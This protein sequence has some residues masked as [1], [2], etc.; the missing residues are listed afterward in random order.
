MKLA[1]LIGVSEY[2]FQNSL[3]ACANDLKLINN[4]LEKLN[5]FE[6]I[7]VIDNSP[8]S[9]TAKRQLTELIN[10][11]KQE[12]IEEFLF[13]YTGHGFRSEDE[14]YY[15][16]S[17][18][19]TN[20]KESTG[21][22]NTEL[23]SLIRNL[24]P[25]LTVKIVDACYSGSTYIKSFA[26]I[27]PFLEKS[28][29]ENGLKN[30]YFFHSSN[31]E[32]TSLASDSYSFFT[33]SICKSMTLNIGPIRYRDI[34][35][36]VADEMTMMAY[37]KPTFI[38]QANYTEIFGDITEALITYINE[39]LDI[40]E[41]TT[42]AR[43]EDFNDTNKQETNILTLVQSK[44]ASEYCTADEALASLDIV[45]CG[46]EATSWPN[47]LADIYSIDVNEIESE[48]GIPNQRPI[49][50]WIIKGELKS[51][52]AKPTYDT[53]EYYTEEYKEIPKKPARNSFMR[54]LS[55][56]YGFD[57][58][59]YKL[60]TVKKERQV[61]TG[62]QAT[63]KLPFI[64]FRIY[65][66]PKYQAADHYNLTIAIIVSM[67]RIALFT[68]KEKLVAESWDKISYPKCSSWKAREINLKDTEAIKRNITEIVDSTAKFIREDIKEK[69]SQ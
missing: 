26:D 61:L 43:N 3:P 53:E 34:M 50:E 46:L 4:T 59:E 1:I 27:E 8:T 14:F 58:T 16:F 12:E 29:R 7:H 22:Q 10:K 15:T 33:H 31:A 9:N 30:I 5:K 67:N 42:T 41:I 65:F 17:D 20:R 39:Q 36:Y 51:Y 52:F 37:P 38:V 11:Y 45:R 32:E 21:L 54:V 69:L 24:E 55:I 63:V 64:G 48:Y 6:A 23:D 47:E 28:A 18:F 19:E 57:D 56:P 49:G 44:T 2:N 66:D 40:K 60:E 13:Y 35:A 25:Q 68:S 62:I